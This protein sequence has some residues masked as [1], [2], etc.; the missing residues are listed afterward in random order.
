[1]SKIM[2][3]LGTF[4]KVKTSV[5]EGVY[6]ELV[7]DSVGTFLSEVGATLIAFGSSDFESESSGQGVLDKFVLVFDA[8]VEAAELKYCCGC[9]GY[10]SA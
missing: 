9:C 10:E 6:S 4:D 1:M 7:L 2:A 8:T 5:V 3:C